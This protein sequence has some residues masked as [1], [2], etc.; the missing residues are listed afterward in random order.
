MDANVHAVDPSSAAYKKAR[1]LHN[2]TTRNREI[3][4]QL[5]WTPFRA[6]EKRYKARFPPP[7]LG[8]VLDLAT[9]DTSRA[10]ECAHGGW[11]GS[12]DAVEW[13]EVRTLTAFGEPGLEKKAYAIPRI[14]GANILC[15]AY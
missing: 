13:R 11:I 4:A 5:E 10:E 2:K 1:R 9:M 15:A 7:D 14:P 12:T 8:D 6:A 3:G